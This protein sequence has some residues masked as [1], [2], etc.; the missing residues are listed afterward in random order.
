MMSR[1][2]RT[3]SLERMC[4]MLLSEPVSRLSTQITRWPRRSSSSQRCDPTN[5][6]PPVTT[7]VG[8]DVNLQSAG[9]APQHVLVPVA[10]RQLL[11]VEV[12]E[13][14]LGE[15]AGGAELVPERRECDRP[16][17]ALGERDDPGA[18]V[19]QHILA[20]VQV[21]CA[22]D[23]AGAARHPGGRARRRGPRPG[24]SPDRAGACSIALFFELLV[25]REAL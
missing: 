8:M 25:P 21:P 20:V 15:L 10:D 11:G 19:S 22:A 17:V 14:R 1:L 5:P 3:K 16:P 24:G 18:G 4:S 12:L 6:A 7:L 9:G 13:Q 23:G 2:S